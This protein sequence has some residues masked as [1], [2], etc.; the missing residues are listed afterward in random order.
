MNAFRYALSFSLMLLASDALAGSAHD[1]AAQPQDQG[2]S[3]HFG[4]SFAPRGLYN[5]PSLCGLSSA[6]AV[7]DGGGRVIGY[8]CV[9]SANGS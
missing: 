8:E 2:M 3:A 6:S 4:P 7:S 1:R 9:E 5:N